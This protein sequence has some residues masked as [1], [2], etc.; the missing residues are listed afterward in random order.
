MPRPDP[1]PP[2]T[3]AELATATTTTLPD[4]TASGGALRRTYAFGAF[5]DAVGFM[6]EAAPGCDEQD[7]HPDWANSWRTVTVSLSTHEA[8]GVV[9]ERD[10][11]LARHLDAV[12]N[13]RHSAAS[14]P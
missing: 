6:A 3:D 1:P 5:A 4:W 11:R 9:T 8:G 7:H 13:R 12:Y 10:V 2:L 14:M